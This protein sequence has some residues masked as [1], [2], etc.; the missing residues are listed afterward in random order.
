MMHISDVFLFTLEGQLASK[1]NTRK[2]VTNRRTGRPMLIKSD[3]A[4]KVIPLFC[5]QLGILFGARPTIMGPVSLTAMVF[6]DSN[7]PDLDISLLADLLQM[8]R[9]IKNDRQIIH[10]AITKGVDPQRPRVVGRLEEV[11]WVRDEG[12]YLPR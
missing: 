4:R 8:A 5:D 1:S 7:R 9:V 11:E 6:Y 12:R 3:R 10:H 2:L